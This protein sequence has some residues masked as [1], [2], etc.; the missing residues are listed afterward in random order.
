MSSM[1]LITMGPVRKRNAMNKLA[2]MTLGGVAAVGGAGVVALV[3]V[4]INGDTAPTAPRAADELSA[5]AASPEAPVPAAIQAALSKAAEEA[6]SGAA[7]DAA[8]YPGFDVV[9]IAPDGEALIAGMAVAQSK[10]LLLLDG[11]EHD[12]VDT[13]AEGRFVSF[14]TLPPSDQPRVLSLRMVTAQG[15]TDSEDRV[16]IA[17]RSVQA[18]PESKPDTGAE[19][20]AADQ[21]AALATQ[22]PATQQETPAP[23][24]ET[25]GQTPEP[26]LVDTIQEPVSGTDLA[27]DTA[28]ETGEQD[29]AVSARQ[30]PD[31]VRA[32]TPDAVPASQPAPEGPE[33]S[34]AADSG[35]PPADAPQADATASPDTTDSEDAQA[36]AGEGGTTETSASG[37]ASSTA[38][39]ETVQAE[40]VQVEAVQAETEQ[41][42]T[43]QAET[44]QAG[45][46]PEAPPQLTAAAVSATATAVAQTAATDALSPAAQP[47]QAG[48]TPLPAQP[49]AGDAATAPRIDS[50]PA[51]A[52]LAP[53]VLLANRQ[54]VRVLQSGKTVQ[55][56]DQVALDA[57]TYS[58]EGEVALSGRGSGQ[59]FVRVYLDNTP[60]TT[61]RISEDGN[62]R[63]E[64]PNVDTGVY[65]LRVDEVGADGAVTSRVESPFKREAPE[66]LADAIGEAGQ[67]LKALTVQPGDTLW[68]IATNRY[69]DG[70][71]YV[72]VFRAN[73]DRIR[74][75]DLIYPGQ[76]FALPEPEPGPT[77]ETP[78][79]E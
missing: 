58:D 50:S 77:P 63:A 71:Q 28:P 66:A 20:G 47:D 19:A 74:N 60:I 26:A 55:D 42:E 36:L 41:V 75:P 35:T 24:A 48:T 34:A 21:V 57:I 31:R 62:W 7:M 15:S 61:S 39:A 5:I 17:P 6:G 51:P 16:I 32:A 4:A 10:V 23:Q 78:P 30:P 69:G 14:L 25:P 64:L 46:E 2:S 44:V 11:E 13:D 45:I 56:T 73:A 33:K 68:A 59:G 70:F 43:E 67:P 1:H 65:T 8:D 22:T 37:A 49:P 3:A 40:T 18:A 38:Q 79:G 53:T 27:D 52:P 12:S 9:R 54:G 76:V 72:Q 29:Q